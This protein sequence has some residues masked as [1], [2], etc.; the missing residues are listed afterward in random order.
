MLE[1]VWGSNSGTRGIH[2]NDKLCLF[3]RLI[4]NENNCPMYQRL[5]EGVTMRSQLDDPSLSPTGIFSKLQMEFNNEEVIVELP[6]DTVD[7]I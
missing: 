4:A 7:N 3:R 6:P 5:A 1:A 2:E